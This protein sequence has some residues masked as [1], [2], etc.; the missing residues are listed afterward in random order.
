MKD[1]LD[2]F[3]LRCLLSIKRNVRL[4][5][6]SVSGAIIFSFLHKSISTTINAR[7][8]SFI[9]SGAINSFLLPILS[10]TQINAWKGVPSANCAD[11]QSNK[12]SPKIIELTA[13]SKKW[14]PWKLPT[15]DSQSKMLNWSSK[16]T[17]WRS[18]WRRRSEVADFLS[19]PA[20]GYC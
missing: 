9:A 7:K 18:L 8:G 17:S 2:G 5:S 1:A 15:T 20:R 13:S 19:R 16:F 6:W 14:S 11:S 3:S 10:H 12:S 4:K